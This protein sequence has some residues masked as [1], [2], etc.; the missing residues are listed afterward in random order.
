MGKDRWKTSAILFLLGVYGGAYGTLELHQGWIMQSRQLSHDPLQLV[1]GRGFWIAAGLAVLLACMSWTNPLLV[2]FVNLHLFHVSAASTDGWWLY[3]GVRLVPTF[4][5]VRTI[6][7]FGEPT[8]RSESTKKKPAATRGR[9]MFDPLLGLRAFACFLVLMG[10]YFFAVVPFTSA[11][12]SHGVTA[13]LRS[14]PWAGVWIFFTLSGYLMGKGFTLGRYSLDEAGM[15]VF[16]RNRFLR[17][18]SVYYGGLLLLTVFRYPAFFLW[19]N[20]WIL[21][22]I[23]IFDFRGDLPVASVGALWSISTEVQFYLLV[24]TLMFALFWIHRKLGNLFL[25][26]PVG[27]LCVGTGLRLLIARY[28][29]M[30]TYGYSPLIPNLDIFL[31]GLSLNLLPQMRRAETESR[32]WIGPVLMAGTA[33]FYVVI[34]LLTAGREQLHMHLEDFWARVPALAVLF[35]AAFIYLAEGLGS[36]V[37]SPGWR[38]RTLLSIQWMGTLTYCLYVFHSDVFESLATVLPVTHGL[39]VSLAYFPVAIAAT[40]VVAAFFYYLVEKPFERKNRLNANG[41]MDAP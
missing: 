6:W 19:R 12:V 31:C 40:F 30:G 32:K 26:V 18:A 15:K 4:L 38:G 33:V 41:L 14:C 28:A 3:V 25:L 29:G 24:P 7:N 36:L 34:C 1:R 39:K 17:I 23:C 5:L 21:L 22:E 27:L 9:Q 10:H 11:G 2:K 13:L 16:L 37:L 8:E 35:A 20:A